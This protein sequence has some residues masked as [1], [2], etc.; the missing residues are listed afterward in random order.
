MMD[1]YEMKD[2]KP[3]KTDVIKEDVWI[4]LVNPT[5]EEIDT[6]QQALQ[7][8]REA[9]TAALDD[10]EGSRTEVSQ[11]Y[12][13][14]LIDAPTREWR[15]NREEFTTYPLSITITDTAYPEYNQKLSERRVNA[16]RDYLVNEC[17]IDPSRLVMD[18][19]GDKERV[20][21]ED[22]RWNRVVVMRVIENDANKQ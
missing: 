2:G 6:V 18:A 15:N 9:L 4:N 10:E 7:I 20:Y 19:R 16:V 8:D 22:Y 14:I 12:T 1:I 13:L 17:G 21:S 5:T 11:K 3:C